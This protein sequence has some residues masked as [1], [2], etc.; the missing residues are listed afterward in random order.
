MSVHLS[1]PHLYIKCEVSGDDSKSAL[2]YASMFLA[3]MSEANTMS[4]MDII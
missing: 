4:V 3:Q 1:L 2:K